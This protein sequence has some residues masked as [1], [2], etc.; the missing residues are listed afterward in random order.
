MTLIIYVGIITI[1]K[2]S[3]IVLLIMGLALNILCFLVDNNSEWK[4][5]SIINEKVDHISNYK[6][7][8]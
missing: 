7:I 3:Y 4:N 5:K 8:L 2:W 1:K 6:T